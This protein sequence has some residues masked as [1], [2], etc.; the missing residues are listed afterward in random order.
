[1]KN[2]K[3]FLG[4]EILSINGVLLKGKTHAQ[5]LQLFKLNVKNDVV[6]VIRRN[7]M[8]IFAKTEA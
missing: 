3:F 8:R 2:K 1:M 7:E 6:L 5:A 4:D